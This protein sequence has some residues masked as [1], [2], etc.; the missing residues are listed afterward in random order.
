[1]TLEFLKVQSVGN[2]FVLIEDAP[3][4]DYPAIAQQVCRRSFGVGSDGLLVL[5]PGPPHRLRMFNPDGTED[6]CGN[7]LRCAALVLQSKGFGERGHLEIHQ[8]GRTIPIRFQG[9]E[10]LTRLDPGTYEPSE[11]PIR[12]PAE[13]A[14]E[15]IQ[16][17]GREYTGHAVSTGSTHLVLPVDDLPSEDEFDAVSPLLEHHELFPERTSIMWM[18]TLG[19]GHVKLRIWERGAGETLGCGTGSTA[20]AIVYARRTDYTGEVRVD[21]PGGTLYVQLNDWKDAPVIRGQAQIVFPGVTSV[22]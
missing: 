11:V 3:G 17:A 8:L 20:S 14:E 6:F 18:Q 5:D 13:F 22:E 19:P 4:L 10:I 2:D 7:G 9:D 12:W 21:N 16:V 15:L 1:M